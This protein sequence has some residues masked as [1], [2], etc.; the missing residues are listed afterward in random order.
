LTLQKTTRCVLGFVCLA[1]IALTCQGGE[2]LDRIVATVNNHVILLSDWKLALSYQAFL[3]D[4][5]VP[6]FSAAERKTSLDHLVDGELIRQQLRPSDFGDVSTEEVKS[7]MQQIRREK[8]GEASD[9]AWVARLA[10]FGLTE[11]ELESKVR[12]EIEQ[13]RAV[14]ARL[15]PGIQVDE[16][17]VAVYYN[18]KF[19]PQLLQSGS[20]VVPLESVAPQIKELLAQQRLNEFLISWLHS[21]RNESTIH[22]PFD[23]ASSGG[24]S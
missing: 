24:G 15:R 1:L 18:E 23:S 8:M 10:Q 9:S 2:V 17:S 12:D 5:R 13:M 21:L 14:E 7:R 6:D 20:K 16:R 22:T 11:R 3:E 19:L 4:R